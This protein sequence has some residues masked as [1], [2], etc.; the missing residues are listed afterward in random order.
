VAAD[1]DGDFVV[2]WNRRAG[3]AAFDV[4]GQ[5]FSSSGEKA[6]AEF[7]INS[8]TAGSQSYPAVARDADGDFV[9]VWTDENYQDGDYSGVFGQRFNSSGGRVGGEFL[10]NTHTTSVQRTAAVAMEDN[11]DF[12]VTWDSYNDP[13]YSFGVRAQRFNA[14]GSKLGPEFAVN[15]RTSNEQYASAVAADADGDFVVVWTSDGQDLPGTP[16]IFGQRFDSLGAPAGAEFQVNTFVGGPQFLPFG[17]S[18]PGAVSMDADGDFVVV[19]TSYGQDQADGYGAFGQRFTSTG[20]QISTEFQLNTYLTGSQQRPAVAMESN[21]DFVPVWSS[22]PTP[23]QD[24]SSSGIFSRRFSFLGG[25]T[26]TPSQT[27]TPTRTPTATTTPTVTATPT[28][29]SPTPTL[30]VTPGGKVIDV[31]LDGEVQALTDGLMILRRLFGFSGLPLTSGAL[32]VGCDRCDP[33]P[34]AAYI[35]GLGFTLDVDDNDDLD[36][37]T[38]GLLIIRRLFGF[39]GVALTNNAAGPGCLRCDPGDIADYIDDLSM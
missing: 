18:A 19:W 31:D 13:D 30:T 17:Y 33:G 29:P 26:V 24:G 3:E 2:V 12:V 39:S 32:G 16:G 11:G 20:L 4:A 21:G 35:D 37:L 10:V 23:A 1:S 7:L 22:G 25:P 27:P 14:A 5:R 38:D 34:I 15:T 28:G 36:P 8:F 9:V 6:G